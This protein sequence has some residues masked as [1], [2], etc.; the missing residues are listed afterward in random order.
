MENRDT[1]APERLSETAIIAK[2]AD[3]VVEGIVAKIVRDFQRSGFL[4]WRED[5]HSM[6]GSGWDEL[7]VVVAM[8]GIACGD[9]YENALRMS[10]RPF[11]AKLER[12]Q[13]DAVWLQTDEASDWDCEDPQTREPYPVLAEDVV[14]YVA[15]RVVKKA[16]SWSNDRIRKCIEY[17]H[18]TG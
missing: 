10:A 13:L 15:D 6:L 9:R 4:A 2:L 14:R 8:D 3:C 1:T 12:F 16:G 5:L 18:E 17:R 7:C 11:I